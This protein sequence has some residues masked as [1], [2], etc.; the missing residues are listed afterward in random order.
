MTRLIIND[1]V[2]DLDPKVKIGI[3]R[4]V[5]S[6]AEL[7]NRQADYSNQFTL[8]PTEKN[9]TILG[10]A[11]Q[12]GN[13]SR[14]PYKKIPAKLSQSGVETNGYLVVNS[15]GN[16]GYTCVFY[17]G[18]LNFFSLIEGKKISDLD[19]SVLEHAWSMANVV[20]SRDNKWNDSG[21][22]YPLIDTIGDGVNFLNIAPAAEW[23]WLTPWIFAKRIWDQIHKEAG[24]GYTGKFLQ[25]ERFNELI[26]NLVT[27][28]PQLNNITFRAVHGTITPFPQNV[29]VEQTTNYIRQY[30]VIDDS[31]SQAVNF[32]GTAS[33]P[34]SLVFNPI[35]KGLYSF[36]FNVNIATSFFAKV[37][38]IEIVVN[39]V[40][41]GLPIQRRVV[42]TFYAGVDFNS[43]QC[44]LKVEDVEME[45]DEFITMRLFFYPLT[46][47]THHNQF[48]IQ[49]DTGITLTAAKF[50]TVLPGL[51][52]KIS[53]N[54]Y[55]MTQTDFIKNICQR[56]CLIPDCEKSNDSIEYFQ[57]SEIIDN[58]PNA[59]DWSDKVTPDS[60]ISFRDSLY[61][62]NS[63]MKWAEAKDYFTKEGLPVDGD[64]GDF[65]FVVDDEVLEINKTVL[66]LAFRP[67]MMVLRFLGIQTPKIPYH[68]K[69]SP[70][71]SVWTEDVGPRLLSLN[72]V[73]GDN[74]T[75]VDQSVPT[76]TVVND[77][78][79][80]CYFKDQGKQY[81]LT[82]ENA[83]KNDYADLIRVI[84]SY[85][86]L[87]EK[88]LLTPSDVNKFNF[89][90]PVYIR[91]H[92]SYFYMIKIP[93][94]FDGSYCSVEI[95]KIN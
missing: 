73:S 54:L 66:E 62:Q 64:F 30:V 26:T 57:F 29:G 28:K 21:Y 83:S 76:T 18:N 55:D 25:S 1:T 60:S 85:K 56:F 41:G 32:P 52:W 70:A 61:G 10:N 86:S 91:K 75:Y 33:N 36:D 7:K 79:P 14:V 74:F 89:K 95:I 43:L 63:L 9:R 59:Y 4:Q 15:A 47:A 19:L 8:P 42:K 87:N 35:L 58:I 2:C 23:R 53:E 20:G 3:T 90:V 71:V 81:D 46:P 48:F 40:T 67:S 82:F 37:N 80:F 12:V 5:N 34:T 24:F 84:Q 16:I 49:P 13:V 17:S 38:R 11:E 31:D 39:E 77:N 68:D 92:G 27:N 50:D 44:L 94:Y 51:T 65:A 6:I 72:R 78:V 45:T 69:D 88:C 93:N 22:I